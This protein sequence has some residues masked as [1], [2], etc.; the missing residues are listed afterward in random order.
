MERKLQDKFW[1]RPSI[2]NI[3]SMDST[4]KMDNISKD[5]VTS[6]NIRSLPKQRTEMCIVKWQSMISYNIKYNKNNLYIQVYL[7]RIVINTSLKLPIV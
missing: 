4:Y 2:C 7:P 6:I 3:L 5:N 1:Y